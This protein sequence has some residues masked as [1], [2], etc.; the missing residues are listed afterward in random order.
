[1]MGRVTRGVWR[2]ARKNAPM[3]QAKLNFLSGLHHAETA[4]PSNGGGGRPR[5]RGGAFG[6]AVVSAR[7]PDADAPRLQGLMDRSAVNVAERAAAYRQGGW[8]SFNASE[9][10]YTANQVRKEGEL[11]IR[12]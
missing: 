1:M 8:R 10:P 12:R 3:H 6:G 11:Y 5:P 9:S 7:V 2:R 4:I